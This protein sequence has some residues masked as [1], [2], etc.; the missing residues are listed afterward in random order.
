MDYETLKFDVAEGL[1]TVTLNR[2]DRLNAVS[3]QMCD[4]LRAVVLRIR[5]DASVR[6]LLLTG[7]GRGFCSGAD[8]GPPN[9]PPPD[10]PDLLV[11]DYFNPL[12]SMI[13]D[14]PVPKVAAVN[15]VA[16][17]AGMSL[18]LTFD[19]VLAARSAYFLPA[20][21]NQALVPDSGGSWQV[22]RAIGSARA[23]GFL[24]LNRRLPAQQAADWGLVWECVED[25]VL[26]ER[27]RALALELAAGP[28]VALAQTVRLT[29]LAGRNSL[30]DQLQA[31][32]DAQRLARG[33]Q[34]RQEA[35]R[36]FSEKRKPV[37][38]GR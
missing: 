19:I 18:A 30:S 38:T 4:E 8:Q 5:A 33:T 14:L 15:G 1:A 17:G 34:D 12:Y 28:T 13:A 31:E 25:D 16:A 7:S 37:F 36:A 20:F 35:R 22:T 11:R 26:M 23:N 21:I 9:V 27:A 32:M 2:P 10:D 3:L 29:G 6:A 24:M